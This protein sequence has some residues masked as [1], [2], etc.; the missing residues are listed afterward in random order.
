MSNIYEC[1]RCGYSSKL[2]SN[3]IRHLSKKMPCSA[4]LLAITREECIEYFRDKKMNN[5]D[6]SSSISSF[7]SSSS[8]TC[9]YCDKTFYNYK[10]RWR[11]EKKCK[12]KNVKSTDKD[13][14]IN[15]LRQ[16]VKK[17][18]K[19]KNTTINNITNNNITVVLNGFVDTDVTYFIDKLLNIVCRL[20]L[21]DETC[22]QYTIDDLI[23][24]A[25][26]RIH[27]HPDHPE[28]HNIRIPNKNKNN[29]EVYDGKGWVLQDKN[30]YIEKMIENV[31]DILESK[32][33]GFVNWDEIEQMIND[34]RTVP[35]KNK[36]IKNKMSNMII[37]RQKPRRVKSL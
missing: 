31:I 18:K 9:K 22:L 23:P 17:L 32:C 24:N 25:S 30:I 7:L 4:L 27:F 2:K 5:E 26:R 35:S 6:I 10:N 16:E 8:N 37:S 14:I 20:H 29:V 21:N 1:Q 11:H 33:Q 12:I 15:E 13:E 19:M 3:I 34:Y 36:N 28:N